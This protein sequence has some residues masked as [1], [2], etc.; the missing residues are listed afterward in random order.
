MHEPRGFL[1]G[2]AETPKRRT[3][4]D[5]LVGVA[6]DTGYDPHDFSGIWML[7]FVPDGQVP[8]GPYRSHLTPAGEER[9]L[10]NVP[11]G[12]NDP[13]RPPSDDPTESNDPTYDCNPIG[14]PRTFY[15][16]A[17]RTFEMM[18]GEDRILQ[19][20]QRRRTQSELWL[21]G[22]HLPQGE[23]LDNIGPSWY[24]HSVAEWQGDELVINAVGMDDR[25][26][27]D[28]V[29]YPKS[30]AACIGER[31]RR[32]DADTLKIRMTLYDPVDYTAAWEGRVLR[33]SR[34]PRERMTYFG[35]YGSYSGFTDLMCAPLNFLELRR[36]GAD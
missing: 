29:G 15:N 4:C 5:R 13:N 24:G 25:A 1:L 35:C 2:R 33:F 11:S 22:R 18:H 3:R 7:V 27:L 10:Q 16:E 34:E 23:N 6:Q 12:G 20:L 19:L 14:F 17:I 36:E 9:Y 28:S 8:F 32:V 30:F 31:I 21:D 26:W